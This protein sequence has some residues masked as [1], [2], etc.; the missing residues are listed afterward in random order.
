MEQKIFKTDWLTE[1]RENTTLPRLEKPIKMT[2]NFLI[3]TTEVR[4]SHNNILQVLD[5]K[6]YQPRI[7]LSVKILFW[8]EEEI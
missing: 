7:L 8:N 1:D 5:E 3:K 6:S 4:G 2:E